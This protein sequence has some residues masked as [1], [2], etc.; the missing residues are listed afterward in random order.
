VDFTIGL[1]CTEVFTYEGLMVQKIQEEMGIP[2]TD[3]KKFNVK[4]KVLV[5][6]KDGEVVEMSL[7][8]AQEYARPE[9]HHC[10]DFTAELADISCGGLRAWTGRSV[11]RSNATALDDWCAADS[12]RHAPWRVRDSM[13]VMLRLTKNSATACRCPGRE[14]RYVVPGLSSVPPTRAR[15]RHGVHAV[16]MGARWPRAGSPMIASTGDE[17]TRGRRTSRRA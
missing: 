12:S 4:G 8:K 14:P 17:P 5:Y 9:C 16:A 1:L 6:K 13:K 15:K 10:G 2:L 3:V 7:H 11:L